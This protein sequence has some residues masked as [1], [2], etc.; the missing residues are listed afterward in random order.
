[1]TI[2]DST[3]PLRTAF[4]PAP[5]E[6]ES[7]RS[8][9]GHVRFFVRYLRPELPLAIGVVTISL[10]AIILRL[11]ILYLPA[12]LTAHFDV[13][14][15]EQSMGIGWPV[16]GL[17]AALGRAFGSPGYLFAF[18][19]IAFGAIL[20]LRPML[21]LW[22]YWSGLLGSNLLL[23]LRLMLYDN[24]QRLSML[25]IYARGAGSFVQRM[26]RDL[27]LAYELFAHSLTGV[28]TLLV[29]S[30]VYLTATLLMEPALTL[31]VLAAYGLLY[32]VLML[33]YRGIQDQAERVQ[34]CNEFLTT[35][36]LESIGGFRDIMAAGQF[37]RMAGRYRGQAERLR[38][39]GLRALLWSQSG[40]LLLGVAFSLLTAVP[41]VLILRRLDHIEQVGRL[42][43]YVALLS[44]LLPS[45]AGVWGTGID[46]AL[47]T[48]S[49][50]A[51]R[52]LLTPPEAPARSASGTG[53]AAMPDRIRRIRFDGVGLELDG[54]WI[55]RDLTFEVAGEQLTAIVGQSGSG[56]TTIF[57]LLLRLLTPTCG[58][59]W[60]NDTPLADF[61][62][63]DLRR[64]IG[65]IPQNPFIFNA[66]LRENILVAA[67]EVSPPPQLLADVVAAAQLE[68]LVKSR[69]G[70]GG[71]DARAGYL[72]MRLSA[73]ERQRIAL[74]R[75]LIQDPPIVVCDEYTANIDVMT[76][77]LIQDM[78]LSR[79]AG[80]T[81]LVITHELYNARGVERIL[82]LDRGRIVQA[83]THADLVRA[84]GLYRAMW[85]A[86]RID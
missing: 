29:Q 3:P 24:L 42:I 41:Y 61:D 9:F 32:P 13:A 54:H 28:V 79:L 34:E 69:A 75:L 1:M 65:F 40:E 70:E 27:L 55:L 11:P 18:V 10:L 17:L 73:G 14:Y 20:L 60:I 21:L 43:T 50:R 7:L 5:I 31:V 62:R 63:S 67:G 37:E 4:A 71:L 19:T 83:G 85:E 8:I 82:V 66:S 52:D 80:R 16:S 36:M 86:Q 35:Q 81:R 33:I 53:R 48:P 59:I 39:E 30:A 2:A 38:H 26:T 84:P 15:G 45:L 74:A 12:V 68:D 51:L 76:A 6:R 22:S 64:L 72:G 46:L 44:A 47:T 58:Q 78:M 77:K 56:K 23:R 49:L 57:H 25:A